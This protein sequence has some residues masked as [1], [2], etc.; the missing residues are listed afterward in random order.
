[1]NLVSVIMPAFNAEGTISDSIKSIISQDYQNW[2]LIV[3][4]DDSKDKTVSIVNQ[5]INQDDRIKLLKNTGNGVSSARNVGI[6]NAKGDYICF[7][8]ADDFYAID[9]IGKRVVILNSNKNIR[10]VFCET[11][12]VDNNLN[13]LGWTL[14]G[15]PMVTFKDFHGNSF[16][17]NSLMTKSSVLK[18]LNFETNFT[19]G[20]D[21]LLFQR[22]ARSGIVF[23]RVDNCKVYYRQHQATVLSNFYK[24]E[25]ELLR[26]LDIIYGKD[27][28]CP[29]PVEQYKNGLNYP[30]KEDVILKRR[31]GLFNFLLLNREFNLANKIG[32]EIASYDWSRLSENEIIASIKY[33]T[34]RKFLC[35]SD[36]WQEIF[37]SNKSELIPYFIKYFPMPVYYNFIEKLFDTNRIALKTSHLFPKQKITE[38]VLENKYLSGRLSKYLYLITGLKNKIISLKLKRKKKLCF[39]YIPGF[40]T[41]ED[42]IDQYFRMIWYLNPMTSFIDKIFIPKG[43]NLKIPKKIPIPSHFDHKL[44]GLGSKIPEKLVFFNNDDTNNWSKTLSKSSIILNW[45]LKYKYSEPEIQK[46]IDKNKKL[47]MV[48]RIDNKNERYEG[49]FY[50]KISSEVN[51]DLRKEIN[52]SKE[53]FLVLSQFVNSFKYQKAY[54]FGTGP[55]LELSLDKSIYF[56]DGLTIA[57]NSM[58]KNDPLMEKLDPKIIIASDPIFHAG[59][60]SYA[61]EFRKLLIKSLDRYNA[62]FIT[63]MRDYK[64]YLSNLPSKYK[65]RIIGIPYTIME[66]ANFDLHKKFVL[67][68]HSN[69]LTFL[70]IPVAT[71]FTKH[72]YLV[73]NDGRKLE[74]NNYFWQHDPN[75]QLN[76]KMKE[77]KIT[78]PSF[79]NIDYNDYYISHCETLEK[80]IHQGQKQGYQF[81]NLTPSYIPV[82]K[83]ITVTEKLK[84]AELWEKYL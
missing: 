44:V 20:E 81:Y 78:H 48:W 79:F 36:E 19:N 42:Y 61:G 84:G 18:S 10:A 32:E 68:V 29:S 15:K 54:I 72:I 5:I 1:M 17:T 60:S 64:L 37:S 16:H 13:E 75:S 77:I 76:D 3:I 71:S 46:L 47:K 59:C 52:E 21:W 33:S 25:N 30:P 63:S 22:L 27:I 28:N 69:V 49:S 58:L 41:I 31:I 57:C 6:K 74:Q 70:L 34:I 39:I 56:T 55:S 12:M 83:S 53:K 51:L 9:S 14:K 66:I 82:L 26:V 4:D 7:L 43:R 2:E 38:C 23:H 11:V 24:H 73:G 67:K 50:L 80:M 35:K 65:H 45:N 62:Y 8:D 40:N